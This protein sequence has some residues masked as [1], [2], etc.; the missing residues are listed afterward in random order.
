MLM[1]LFMFTNWW[2][3]TTKK[4]LMLLLKRK[5]GDPPYSRMEKCCELLDTGLA[6]VDWSEGRSS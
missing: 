3:F 6:M 2:K 1:A 4:I 5:R